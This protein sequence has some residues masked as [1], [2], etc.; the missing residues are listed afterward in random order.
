MPKQYLPSRTEFESCFADLQGNLGCRRFSD[1]E[2]VSSIDRLP[3]KGE[4]GWKRGKKGLETCFV[5]EPKH[6]HVSV[7]IW[8]TYVAAEHAAREQDAG[9]VLLIDDRF[10]VAPC[11]YSFPIHRTKNFFKTLRKWIVAFIEIVD[12]WPPPCKRCGESPTIRLVRGGVMHAVM[13]DCP[14]GHRLP[15]TWIYQGLH[16]ASRTFLEHAFKRYHDYRQK[17][18]EKG[19]RLPTPRRVLRANTKAGN[20]A[21]DVSSQDTGLSDKYPFGDLDNCPDF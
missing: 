3:K 9:W 15:A 8:T 14:G 4:G 11:F 12:N 18:A 2:V 21:S 5:Y 7:V 6:G 1:E 19:S 20:S 10:P 16:D 13:F 17:L